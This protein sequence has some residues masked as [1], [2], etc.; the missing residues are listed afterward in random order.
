MNRQVF[1]D[2][3]K[4]GIVSGKELMRGENISRLDVNACHVNH[5]PGK[6]VL[7]IGIERKCT[8]QHK[9]THAQ[10][11]CKSIYLHQ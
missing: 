9:R 7:A 11:E 8:E 4:R 3:R 2:G 10:S 1:P 5:F 6:T